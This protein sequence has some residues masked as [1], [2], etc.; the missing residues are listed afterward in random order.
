MRQIYHYFVADLEKYLAE[1]A[2]MVFKLW[3]K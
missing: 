2:S 1:G 3:Q